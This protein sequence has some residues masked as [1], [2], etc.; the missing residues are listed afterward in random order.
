M[1]SGARTN[2]RFVDKNRR[3]TVASCK[4]SGFVNQPSFKIDARC[5]FDRL[6]SPLLSYR[7][8][9]SRDFNSYSFRIRSIREKINFIGV[10]GK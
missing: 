2:T 6:V 5:V 3:R 8:F 7:R 9:V 4:T 10:Y 1:I